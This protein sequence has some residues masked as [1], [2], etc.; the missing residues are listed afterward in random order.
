MNNLLWFIVGGCSMEHPY[1]S[2]FQKLH[3]SLCI[4]GITR[5]VPTGGRPSGRPYISLRILLVYR[6][7]VAP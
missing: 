7:F 1:G 6:R 2:T 5:V 4:L 3:G